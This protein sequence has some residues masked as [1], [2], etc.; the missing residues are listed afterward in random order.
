MAAKAQKKALAVKH[1]ATK[2]HIHKTVTVQQPQPVSTK[3]MLGKVIALSL[4]VHVLGNQRKISTSNVKVEAD[5]RWIGV[6]K[7]LV[8]SDSL[9]KIRGVGYRAQAYVR[10]HALPSLL[11]DS[12]YLIPTDNVD[13]VNKR[14][15]EFTVEHKQLVEQFV[16]EYDEMLQESK[17]RLGKLFTESDYPTKDGLTSAFGIT[18]RYISFDVPVSLEQVSRDVYQQ[19]QAKAAK[20]W[21][22]AREVWQQLLRKEFSE[23]VGH[24]VERLSPSKDG[25]KKVIRDSAV[26][27][28]SEWIGT[29]NPRNIQGDAELK[30]LVDKA[31]ALVKGV[32]PDVLRE[33][34]R[35]RNTMR[36]SF[37]TIKS[38]LDTL[39]VLKPSREVSF[40]ED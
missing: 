21:D 4:D 15:I 27:N 35:A 22:A 32:N 2:R 11:K 19:E 40:D 38:T 23:V 24:L 5:P 33:D 26:A 28:V 10:S 29:F 39:V 14:L 36:A 13:V 17:T 34:E 8:A 30:A 6:T 18:W 20:S 25:K 12:V 9:G 3:E 1:T 37:E 7:K 31:N 16:G